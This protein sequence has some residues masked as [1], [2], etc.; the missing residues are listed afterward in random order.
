MRKDKNDTK[1]LVGNNA[2]QQFK[3][4]HQHFKVLEEK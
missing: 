4:V 2:S 3:T 1:L